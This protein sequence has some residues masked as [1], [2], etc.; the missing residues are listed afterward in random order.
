[1]KLSNVELKCVTNVKVDHLKT[2]V[3]SYKM[4]F[5]KTAE[6]TAAAT[7]IESFKIT[8]TTTTT[9]TELV[10]PRSCAMAAGRGHSPLKVNEK[11]NY[12]QT[13]KQTNK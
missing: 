9:T 1:M 6:A 12:K 4:K 8:T 2:R 13:N 3:N 10:S 11:V 7:H 5:K